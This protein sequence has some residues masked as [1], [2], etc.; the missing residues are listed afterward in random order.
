[1]SF[2][3]NVSSH[4]SGAKRIALHGRL[5][6]N[7]GTEFEKGLSSL[8]E[9]PPELVVV[10]MG[11]LNYLSSAGLRV[12]FMLQKA[13][14]ARDGRVIFLK[15]TPGVR[16]VFDVI[17]ALPSMEVFTSWEELDEYLDVIQRRET[18]GDAP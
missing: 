15:L 3:M 16:K 8:I 9:I 6:S 14:K 11:D 17:N 13:V 10:D 4:R 2:S 18:E 5:D 12:I 1:M 7:A